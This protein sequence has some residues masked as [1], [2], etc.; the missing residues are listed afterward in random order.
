MCLPGWLEGRVLPWQ[1]AM[2]TKIFAPPVYLRP[3]WDAWSINGSSVPLFPLGLSQEVS[4][5][6]LAEAFAP[7]LEDES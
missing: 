2:R 1:G 7:W 3:W 6:G 4:H 5:T